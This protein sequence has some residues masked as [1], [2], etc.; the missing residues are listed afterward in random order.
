MCEHKLWDLLIAFT[1]LQLHKQ[2]NCHRITIW[3]SCHTQH[4]MVQQSIVCRSKG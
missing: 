2:P 3:K 4:S 1:T